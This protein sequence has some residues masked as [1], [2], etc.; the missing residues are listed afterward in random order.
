M[1]DEKLQDRAVEKEHRLSGH[2]PEAFR[3]EADEEISEGPVDRGT[4][5]HLD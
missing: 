2:L 3:R 4:R 1:F 5:A